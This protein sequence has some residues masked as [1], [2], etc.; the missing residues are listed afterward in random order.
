LK[1]GSVIL[2]FN[3]LDFSVAADPLFSRP[4]PCR[5]QEGLI[6]E[7]TKFPARAPALTLCHQ[8][9]ECTCCNI[10]HTGLIQHNLEAV[11]D[12]GRV[13][14]ECAAVTTMMACRPCDPVVGVG[15]KQAVCAS[16][17][18]RWYSACAQ[19]FFSFTSISQRLKLCD[20]KEMLCSPLALLVQGGSEMCTQAGYKVS[21]KGACFDGLPTSSH[22]LCSFGDLNAPTLTDTNEVASLSKYLA[23]IG[24]WLTTSFCAYM[25][26]PKIAKRLRQIVFG[27]VTSARRIR[28]IGSN[29][30]ATDPYHDKNTRRGSN[31]WKR[32]DPY[33]N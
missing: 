11:L 1:L 12:S 7:N 5:A 32:E 17:C 19:D 26:G 4:S 3:V 15:M 10:S 29:D 14:P 30:P 31:D 2:L 27:E 9:K 18:D 21:L 6:V 24:L 28:G 33:L 23:M 8:Y 20:D 13:S 16:T 25:V 22:H